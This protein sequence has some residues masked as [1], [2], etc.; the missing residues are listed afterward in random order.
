MKRSTGLAKR[1]RVAVGSCLVA[2][3]LWAASPMGLAGAHPGHDHGGSSDSG[4]AGG[5]GGG[6]S[7]SGGGKTK[8]SKSLCAGGDLGPAATG[9]SPVGR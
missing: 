3:C 9:C 6:A 4:S 7:K 2:V 8:R 5:G 1:T